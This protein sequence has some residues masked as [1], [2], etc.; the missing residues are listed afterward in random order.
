M[1]KTT[2]LG[3]AALALAT[4][5]AIAN[6]NAQT[7][8]AAAPEATTT[9]AKPPVSH[10]KT[11]MHKTKA[12]KGQKAP[13]MAKEPAVEDLNSQSLNA[14]KSGQAFTPPAKSAQ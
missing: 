4:S 6:A 1:R 7:A 11:G 14:A 5:G 3:L 9:P 12:T 13:G 10:H 8:P 2:L